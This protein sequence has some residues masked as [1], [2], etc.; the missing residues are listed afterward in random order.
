MIAL[1]HEQNAGRHNNPTD[2]LSPTVDAN[3][4]VCVLFIAEGLGFLWRPDMPT[5]NY[6]FP[7]IT[8]QI[9][10]RF[11]GKVAIGRIDECWPW[12]ASS[13]K[14]GYGRF[15]IKKVIYKAHRVAFAIHNGLFNYK[16]CV[17]HKCDNPC[18]CNP[19]HLFTGTQSQNIADCISKGR[20]RTTPKVGE[21]NNKAKLTAKQVAEI[22]SSFR[23]IYGVATA[24]SK[25]YN[26]YRTTITRIA[27]R[28]TWKHIA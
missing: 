17:L 27:Q 3:L 21:E 6:K 2:K 23:P 11:W 14:L 28:Q 20:K 22:R 8:T 13:N 10:Q 25:K 16:L 26:V 15:V 7:P 5:H 9:A 19:K 12:Q 18:C 1:C 24:L 4:P